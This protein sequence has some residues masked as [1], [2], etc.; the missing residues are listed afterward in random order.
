MTDP[1]R[2]PH[3][4]QQWPPPAPGVRKRRRVWPWVLGGFAGFLLLIVVVAG[5][6]TA[7]VSAGWQTATTPTGASAAAPKPAP[8]PKPAGPATTATD[9]TYQVGTD[10]AAG[11]Y[12]TPGP[13][14]DSVIHDCYWARTKDD[15][16]DLTA[17]IANGNAQGPGSVT[18][19]AGEFFQTSG[20]CTW[21][22]Q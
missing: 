5:C 13:G 17:I 12:K 4:P 19:K 18:I 3:T 10:I 6:N 9:G 15:S 7:A 14:A 16:G 21:T 8:A 2:H 22:K 1:Y 11:R 20:G